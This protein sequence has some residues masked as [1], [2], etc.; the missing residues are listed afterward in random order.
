MLFLNEQI[1]SYEVSI[2]GYYILKDCWIFFFIQIMI[3][4]FE[5]YAI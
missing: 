4:L 3:L 5:N 1:D 2:H